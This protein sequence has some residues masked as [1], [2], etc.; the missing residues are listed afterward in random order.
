MNIR[1]PFRSKATPMPSIRWVNRIEVEIDRLRKIVIK[2]RN[3][4]AVLSRLTLRNLD[5]GPEDSTQTRIVPT[6]LRPIE[7]A[8]VGVH[9]NADTPFPLIRPRTRI[10]RARI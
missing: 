8:A 1:P 4:P 10:A 6:L 7:L 5:V 3:V 9:R 2:E